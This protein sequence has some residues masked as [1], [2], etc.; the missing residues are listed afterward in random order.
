MWIYYVNNSSVKILRIE[1]GLNKNQQT[2]NS[3]NNLRNRNN[4]ITLH[5]LFSKSTVNFIFKARTFKAMICAKK[6]VFIW[7]VHMNFKRHIY[8]P[9]TKCLVFFPWPLQW[10]SIKTYSWQR[11]D[12]S[13]SSS[14]LLRFSAKLIWTFWA[15]RLED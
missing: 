11:L 15:G 10:V 3:M 12:I 7:H 2:G 4:T 14:T 6:E 8:A 13:K 9:E 1:K 5:S